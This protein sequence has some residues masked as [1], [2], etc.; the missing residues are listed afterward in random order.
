MW[1]KL[2][3]YY[4]FLI[5]KLVNKLLLV[6]GIIQR[7]CWIVGVMKIV[8]FHSWIVEINERKKHEKSPGSCVCHYYYYQ[9][10]EQSYQH[11]NISAHFQKCPIHMNFSCIVALKSLKINKLLSLYIVHSI[12]IIIKWGSKHI[13]SV[14][15]P[16]KITVIAGSSHSPNV[17]FFRDAIFVSLLFLFSYYCY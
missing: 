16:N 4:S 1:N 12:I 14:F 8:D 17:F 7:S 15:V 3:D 9:M 6:N 13:Q 2:F 5:Y 10:D 11:K